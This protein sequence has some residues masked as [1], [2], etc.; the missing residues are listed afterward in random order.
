MNPAWQGRGPC[1]PTPHPH[2][3]EAVCGG[4][5][6]GCT[7]LTPLTQLRRALG[8][9]PWC[10]PPSLLSIQL[11]GRCPRVLVSAEPSEGWAGLAWCPG[12]RD[13]GLSLSSGDTEE[14][15]PHLTSSGHQ[16]VIVT[17][18]ET[19]SIG[20]SKL[21]SPRLID[22]WE[23]DAGWLDH[24]HRALDVA[25]LGRRWPKRMAKSPAG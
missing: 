20:P 9:G 12:R 13:V 23:G 3:R 2:L 19:N 15:L 16:L 22:S 18:T 17:S 4:W 14:L 21:L 1:L 5:C 10:P 25:G 11:E 8:L 6:S 24:W 7:V